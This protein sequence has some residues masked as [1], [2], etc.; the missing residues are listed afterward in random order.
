MIIVLFIS[1]KYGSVLLLKS[2]FT[3][4]FKSI[5]FEIDEICF[6]ADKITEYSVEIIVLK[7]IALLS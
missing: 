2:K 3:I 1:G 6:H 4:Y 5:S 7:N